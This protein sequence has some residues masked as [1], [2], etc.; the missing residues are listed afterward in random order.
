MTQPLALELQEAGIRVL[1][2]APGWIE[3][4]L[5]DFIPTDIKQAIVRSCMIGPKRFGYD[6]EYAHL[7]TTCIVNPCINGSVI[8]LAAGSSIDT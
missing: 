8:E 7:V 3:T 6:I 2:I 4:P 5:N 1:T